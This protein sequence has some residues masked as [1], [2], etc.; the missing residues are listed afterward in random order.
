M[1]QSMRKM[2]LFLSCGPIQCFSLKNCS[3]IQFSSKNCKSITIKEKESSLNHNHNKHSII[4]MKT[5]WKRSCELNVVFFIVL[6]HST[7]G[8]FIDRFISLVNGISQCSIVIA[9]RICPLNRRRNGLLYFLI[10]SI[11]TMCHLF[12][13]CDVWLRNSLRTWRCNRK[14]L[15]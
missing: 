5:Y 10:I 15:R 12:N 8:H 14:R 13:M 2:C 1:N 6:Y 11:R 3:S 7:C 9:N 4:L